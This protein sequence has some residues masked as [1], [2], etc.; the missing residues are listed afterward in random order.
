[1]CPIVVTFAD[2]DSQLLIKSVLKSV[3]LR[4]TTYPVVEQFAQEVKE[5][6]KELIPKMIEA[7]QRGDKAVL[8]RDK[9]FYQQCS[10]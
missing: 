10:I 5:R 6:R 4:Q 8:V 2:T 7:R 3:N 9:L 1:M